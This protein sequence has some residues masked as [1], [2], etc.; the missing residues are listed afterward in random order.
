MW[1][2]FMNAILAGLASTASGLAAEVGGL[3]VPDFSQDS[4]IDPGARDSE[5]GAV[6]ESGQAG[7]A[8]YDQMARS[9]TRQFT[10]Q[11]NALWQVFL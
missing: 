1:R 10:S 5:V 9:G 8:M 6:A 2:S 7:T 3:A 4:Q 11:K